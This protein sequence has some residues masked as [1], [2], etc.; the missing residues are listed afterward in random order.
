MSSHPV[1]PGCAVKPKIVA[2]ID[3]LSLFRGNLC[4]KSSKLDQKMVIVI[5]RWSLFGGGHQLRFDCM[6]LSHYRS[7]KGHSKFCLQ[8]VPHF[9]EQYFHR[10]N[11]LQSYEGK[12]PTHILNLKLFFHYF[13]GIWNAFLR[14]IKILLFTKANIPFFSQHRS[15]NTKQ[16]SN[17]NRNQNSQKI[18][19]SRAQS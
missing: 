10:P 17:A 16:T 6:N 7:E 4:N 5:D 14:N 12:I 3:R 15:W 8:S 19:S 13:F 9:S 18:V 1:Q 2:V 11:L